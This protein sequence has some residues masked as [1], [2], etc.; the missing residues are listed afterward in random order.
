MGEAHYIDSSGS[1]GQRGGYLGTPLGD[2]SRWWYKAQVF[3][4]ARTSTV[5]QIEDCVELTPL[6]FFML[7]FLSDI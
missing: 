7:F 4:V 2:Q 3:V 5:K 1:E 6:T